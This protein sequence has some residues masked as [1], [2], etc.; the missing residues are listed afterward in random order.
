M[1]ES[2]EMPRLVK[3]IARKEMVF[4]LASVPGGRHLVFGGSDFTVYQVDAG[5]DKPGPRALGVH[6]S[7]VTGIAVAGRAAISGGYDGQ[8]IWW[9]LDGARRIRAV[10][11]HARWIRKVA[12]SPDGKTVASVADDMICRLWDAETG[13]RRL[14]LA[15]HLATTPH[16]FPSMLY[17]CAFSPDGLHVATGDKVGHI[18]VWEVASGRPT[19]TIEAPGF[20]TWDPTQ[21]RHSIGGIRSLAF[22]SDGRMLA[23][24]GIGTVGNIDHLEGPARVEVFEWRAGR[25]SYES[26]GDLRKGLVERLLFLPDGR[27]LA[28]GGANDGFLLMLD[29]R[30]KSP[31]LQEKM[32]GHVY[33]AAIGGSPSSLFV[34]GHGKIGVYELKA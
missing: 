10:A 25:R 7:Y 20:Y 15:G 27:L 30:S 3:E 6:E 16:H 9:D 24:G 17:A 12:V 22:S 4:A 11:A 5:A 18:V 1:A 28:L 13:A 14:E 29:P 21:R 26:P 34:A 2:P 31:L 23:V 33:D 32:P 8:L 19:A